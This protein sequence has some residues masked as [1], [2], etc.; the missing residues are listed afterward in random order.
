MHEKRELYLVKCLSE[1]TFRAQEAIRLRK[2]V[3]KIIE[4]R[5]GR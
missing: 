3:Q 1:M 5:V 4:I 2:E